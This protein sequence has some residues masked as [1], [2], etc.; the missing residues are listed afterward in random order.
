MAMFGSV[1]FQDSVSGDLGNNLAEF[2]HDMMLLSVFIMSLVLYVMFRIIS[3]KHKNRFFK[4]CQTME[5]I[6]TVFPIVILMGLWVPS[7]SNL[8]YMNHMGSVGWSFKAIG[9][10]W[11]WTYEFSDSCNRDFSFDSYML[12]SNDRGYNYRLLDVDHRMVLPCGVPVRCLVSSVDV[13]HSFALPSVSVKV[14]AI[15]GRMTQTCLY[16]VSSGVVYGQCSELCGVNHSFMPIAIEFIP[17]EKFL[18]WLHTMKYDKTTILWLKNNVWFK[19]EDKYVVDQ[20]KEESNM[21]CTILLFFIIGVTV[22]FI[23]TYG[24]G[25]GGFF[26]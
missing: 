21:K 23:M 24:K 8:Y 18:H 10:Q 4:D 9:H 25:G 26:G 5:W 14:D 16:S 1:K 3:S 22:T 6:W 19:D 7:V 17:K 15:P 12:N 2:Y 13:L 20:A 11:Y